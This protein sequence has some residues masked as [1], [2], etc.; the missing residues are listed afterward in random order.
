MKF[1][2]YAQI[3]VNTLV[4]FN[5]LPD[6]TVF[7]VIE[8][9]GLRVRVVQAGTS[10]AAQETDVSLCHIPSA[11]QVAAITKPTEETP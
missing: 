5:E 1:K 11:E 7:S 2:S 6:A 8:R 4:T 3:K 9:N 10:F